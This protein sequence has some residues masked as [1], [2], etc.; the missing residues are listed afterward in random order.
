MTVMKKEKLTIEVPEQTAQAYRDASPERRRRAEEAMQVALM[1][2]EE[3]AAA[4]DRLT[5]RTSQYAQERGLTEE[6][7]ADLLREDD[8]A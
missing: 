7:L 5:S 3:V 2:R 6:K 1:S 4:F 8:D